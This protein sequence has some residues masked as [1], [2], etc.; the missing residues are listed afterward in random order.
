MGGQIQKECSEAWEG[1]LKHHHCGQRPP[2]HDLKRKVE[3]LGLSLLE[4]KVRSN[5]KVTPSFHGSIKD[6]AQTSRKNQ[7]PEVSCNQ[8]FFDVTTPRE[9]IGLYFN[10]W[11]TLLMAVHQ[12]LQPDRR[13]SFQPTIIQSMVPKFLTVLAFY[14]EVRKFFQLLTSPKR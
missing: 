7:G 13:V 5:S 6:G 14:S 9:K 12:P 3:A 11:G 4:K 1:V 10:S 8:Y 2:A